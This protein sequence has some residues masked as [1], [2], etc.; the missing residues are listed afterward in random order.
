MNKSD[1]EEKRKY[2]AAQKSK[3]TDPPIDCLECKECWDFTT[4]FHERVFV[5]TV[6]GETL[7]SY[8]GTASV[9]YINAPAECP[10]RKK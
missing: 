8:F 1:R 9:S 4:L 2:L 6:T 7:H 10:R 5:C 3:A